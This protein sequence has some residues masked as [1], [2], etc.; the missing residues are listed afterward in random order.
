MNTA[1]PN[2]SPYVLDTQIGYRLRIANQRHLEV[3]A[4]ELP[5]LTPT[6][7][8]VLARL[9]EIGEASQNHLGRLVRL[10][11]ATIKG[12]VSRLADKG[13]VHINPSQTDRRRLLI[14]LTDTGADFTNVAIERAHSISNR[15][16]ENLTKVEETMLIELLNKL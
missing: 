15:T 12:V 2:K 13:F 6:Q 5:E 16:T 11:G 4:L 8:A 10:D 7:F 1:T 3:F 9:K 14:S